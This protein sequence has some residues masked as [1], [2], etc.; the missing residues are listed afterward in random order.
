MVFSWSSSHD[1]LLYFCCFGKGL[2]PF[3]LAFFF[4]L[5]SLRIM[6]PSNPY[7]HLLLF[8][9]IKRFATPSS[10]LFAFDGDVVY[11]CKLLVAR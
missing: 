10:N 9:Q 6:F 1:C 2:T 8:L 5:R 4:L 11:R 7:H 3:F